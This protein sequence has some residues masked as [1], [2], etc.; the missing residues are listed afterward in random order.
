MI[1]PTLKE[2]RRY[3]IPNLRHY[4]EECQKNQKIMEN[5]AAEETEKIAR[6]AQM[7]TLLEQHSDDGQV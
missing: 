3:T 4:I 5:A 6:A 1:V 2:A 7:I